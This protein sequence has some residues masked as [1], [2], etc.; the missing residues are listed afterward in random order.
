MC[1]G[2]S[3]LASPSSAR[4]LAEGYPCS[5]VV[6]LNPP[7]S[8]RLIAKGVAALP[9]VKRALV[10]GRII[11]AT[12]TTNGFV[13]EEILGVS[14]DKERYSRGIVAGGKL[15]TTPDEIPLS[16]YV[17]IDGKVV[18]LPFSQVLNDFDADDVFIKSANAVDPCGNVGVLMSDPQGGTIGKALPVVV[19]RGA[20]LVVPVG[21]EKLIPS[22]M[23]ASKRC[24]QRRWKFSTGLGV[25]LMPIVNAE[26]VTEI[27][28]LAILTGVEA[29]HV[30]SGGTQGSEGAVVLSLEGTEERVVKAFNLVI[31]IKNGI[32]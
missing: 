11:I 31:S 8:K 29:T 10:K 12:G 7:E 16:P 32:A 13:A 23:E 27:H 30:A 19:P 9:S 1:F 25:G 4:Y 17:V 14:L 22:V 2:P 18:D 5:A 26:V 6:V 15:T 3:L 20:H 21:L 24:G 28:A